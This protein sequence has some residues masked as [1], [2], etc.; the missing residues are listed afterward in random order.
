MSESPLITTAGPRDRLLSM[1]RQLFGYGSFDRTANGLRK[2]C[3]KGGALKR[4]LSVFL[5]K[6]SS[7]PVLEQDA[8]SI[9]LK[10]TSLHGNLEYCGSDSLLIVNKEWKE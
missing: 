6:T 10:R 3:G 2:L 5:Y 4:S 1:V 9:T 7:Q 8:F